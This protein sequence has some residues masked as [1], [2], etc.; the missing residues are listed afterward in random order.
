MLGRLPRLL[1]VPGRLSEV[2]G[3]PLEVPGRLPDV[4]GRSVEATE[5][6]DP[7][8][9]RPLA[10]RGRSMELSTRYGSYNLPLDGLR[11]TN[12]FLSVARV[13]KSVV[14]VEP[15]EVGGVELV[16]SRLRPSNPELSDEAE[17]EAACD[18]AEGRRRPVGNGGASS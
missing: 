6:S 11:F 2:P 17:S 14:G 5:R 1:E 16:L 15:A 12:G 10:V 9:R 3:L 18:N 7:V 13:E 8:P 4:P